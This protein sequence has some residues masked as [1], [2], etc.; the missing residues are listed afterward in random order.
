MCVC[1]FASVIKH[2]QL[3]LIIFLQLFNVHHS[4][5]LLLSLSVCA[6]SCLC[7]CVCVCVTDQKSCKTRSNESMAQFAVDT[8]NVADMMRSIDFQTGTKGNR[9]IHKHN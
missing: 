8:D 5:F 4:G 6:C 3:L 7:V 1:V 2:M 9:T